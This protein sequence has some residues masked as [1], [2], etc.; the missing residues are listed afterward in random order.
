[1]IRHSTVEISAIHSDFRKTLV[2]WNAEENASSE[3]PPLLSVKAVT[4][5]IT[6]GI[7]VN[8]SIQMI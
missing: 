1:M 3:N 7:M 5:I 4:P 8:T 6:S 2:Y